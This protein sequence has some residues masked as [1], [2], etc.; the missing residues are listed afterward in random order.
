LEFSKATWEQGFVPKGDQLFLLVTLRK[1]GMSSEHAYED[2]FLAPDRFQWQSQN[3]T[4]QNSKHGQMISGHVERK[5]QVHLL[6]RITKKIGS[7]AAPFFYCGEVD[8][9]S[10]HGEKPITVEWRLRDVVPVGLREMFGVGDGG[11]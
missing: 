10:W 8:F 11:L 1:D 7:K 3:Q 5:I 2:R 4:A 6:V 9:L